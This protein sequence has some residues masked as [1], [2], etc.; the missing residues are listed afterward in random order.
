MLAHALALECSLH[1]TRLCYIS[2]DTSSRPKGFWFPRR[3]CLAAGGDS[4]PVLRCWR[5]CWASYLLI[6][7][8]AA[9]VAAGVVLCLWSQGAEA[10]TQELP[11]LSVAKLLRKTGVVGWRDG[12]TWPDL[13]NRQCSLLALRRFEDVAWHPGSKGGQTRKKIK[14]ASSRTLGR[15]S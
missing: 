6:A 11:F 10:E 12:F 3:P 4:S 8:Y 14:S 7:F 9:S 1:F 15:S 2:V 13:C 5:S